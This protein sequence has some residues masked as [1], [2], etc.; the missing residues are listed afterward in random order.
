MQAFDAP[1]M[2]TNC[3]ARS[4][5][6]VATQSLMLMNGEFWLSQAT[7]LADRAQREPTDAL[8]GELIA[9][10]PPRWE[11]S[12]PLWQFGYGSYDA[13]S[14]RTTSFTPCRIGPTRAGK[15][16]KRLP[17]ERSRLGLPDMPTAATRATIPTFAA[18]RR[19]TA[20]ADGVLTIDGT[21]SHGSPNGDGV[22][23]RIV[24]SSLGIAG[25]WS[26]HNGQARNRRRKDQCIGRRYG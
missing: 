13:A 25:E 3:E 10:L 15:V 6:T 12:A 16:A 23:S 1:V 7:A 4:S 14:G 19:W 9:D 26:A 18:I 21:L 11:S 22:R 2:V 24:I 5:S 17:D 20:P 8:P